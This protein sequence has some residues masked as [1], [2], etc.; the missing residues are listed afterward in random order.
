MTSSRCVGNSTQG[1]VAWRGA[2]RRGASC[3]PRL[4]KRCL[5][6]GVWARF[7]DMSEPAGRRRR[8]LF[9]L[10]GAQVCK[11]TPGG[12]G[13]SRAEP[14]QHNPD[15]TRRPGLSRGEGGTRRNDLNWGRRR[16]QTSQ[17]EP[18]TEKSQSLI[19]LESFWRMNFED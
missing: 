3:E 6:F 14:S 10:R 4:H 15:Q 13:R 19:Q 17:T 16:N 1:S 9:H 12:S 5:C 2:V 18:K 11:Q 7:S 8:L